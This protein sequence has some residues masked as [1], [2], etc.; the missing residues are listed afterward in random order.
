MPTVHFDFKTRGAA[1]VQRNV[2]RV[3][4]SAQAA[5]GRSAA[6]Q[7]QAS[8]EVLQEIAKQE[9]STK[10][11]QEKATATTAKEVAKR[12]SAEAKGAQA[13]AKE[14]QKLTQTV[15]RE[16]AAQ[17]AIVV[18]ES[19]RRTAVLRAAASAMRGMWSTGRAVAGTLATAAMQ[20]APGIHASMGQAR[21]AA[22]ATETTLNGALY[23][24][25][26][27]GPQAAQMQRM[28]TEA[29]TRG[30]LRGLTSDQV[31]GGIAAAQTQFSVLGRG[32]TANMTPAEREARRM[33][34]F[35][36]QLQAA[37]FA[38]N[39]YQDPAEVM[40]VAGMLGAQGVTGSAQTS[41][42]YALTGIAQAGS[43]ELRDVVGTA[44]GPLMQNIANATARLGANATPEARA[45]AVRQASIRTMAVG[46]VGAGGGLT[47][48]D[49]LNAMAKIDRNLQS[50]VVTGHL[51]ESLSARRGGAAVANE[52]FETGRDS[53]GQVVRRLR[54]GI[55]SLQA[56]SRL[57]SF[58][59][60]NTTEMLNLLQGGGGEAMV[61]D[62]QVRRLLGGLSSQTEGGESI[63]QRVD[64]MIAQGSAFGIG[65]VA[66]GRGMRD[67]EAQTRIVSNEEL[68]REALTR[69]TGVLGVLSQRVEDLSAR[70]PMLTAALGALGV[71]GAS[72]L[73]SSG[74]GAV[75]GIAAIAAP[76]ATGALGAVAPGAAAALGATAGAATLGAAASTAA[77]GGA[78]LLAGLV[79]GEGINSRI[80]AATTER[81]ADGSVRDTNTF[82]LLTGGGMSAFLQE[83]RDLPSNL[84]A[85]IQRSAPQAALHANA[86]AATGANS[87]PPES[88]ANR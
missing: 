75:R 4:S 46:E 16:E 23:Q 86:S 82:G 71:S 40:R 36:D 11:A 84:S 30:P 81:N 37:E 66:R 22:A 88:R 65:D 72:S 69:N 64:R 8:Q 18:R 34:N 60:G 55:D 41:A 33:A 51:Y 27:G 47:P 7:K 25:G 1:E 58:T 43:V 59:G 77:A 5:A 13:V 68:Q 79:V 48:R 70:F 76:L 57:H 80:A 67:A 32:I 35:Q 63:K 85:A 10:S 39:T 42:L 83:L 62:S 50:T 38:R 53:R 12:V 21:R 24:A 87:T 74:F 20:A 2:Q 14:H 56:V 15:A 54:S 26:I 31:A 6:A 29:V 49:A 19:S 45:E 73:A 3:V 9:A 61:L 52:L 28:L 78:G 44:M 17:T